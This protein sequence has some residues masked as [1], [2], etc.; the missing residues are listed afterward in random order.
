MLEKLFISTQKPRAWFWRRASVIP[1]GLWIILV[2]A[3]LVS[4]RYFSV[5]D[6]GTH[7][8]EIVAAYGNTGLIYGIPQSDPN[9]KK[10]T[11]CQ[12]CDSGIGVFLLDTATGQKQLVH[13]KNS[14][15][16]PWIT[17][18]VWPWSPD[19]GLFIYSHTNLYVC[20]SATG[21]VVAELPIEGLGG[22]A[23]ADPWAFNGV[24]ALTWLDSESFVYVSQQRTLHWFQKTTGGQW[25]ER[26]TGIK[27]G[28]AGL[29]T[30]SSNTIAWQKGNRIWSLNLAS[31][32]TSPVFESKTNHL[33]GFN[34]SKAKGEFLMSCSDNGVDS[35]WRLTNVLSA[36]I[37]GQIDTKSPV[38]NVVW[39]NG[40]QPGC[41]YLSPRDPDHNTLTLHPTLSGGPITLFG[42][43]LVE[44]FTASPDGRKLFIVGAVSNEP[45]AGIWQYDAG[46]GDLRNLV[47]Y[48]A[49]PSAYARR[50]DAFHGFSA[51][52]MDYYLYPP[53]DFNRH[54]NKKYPLVI[55]D[56]LF[57]RTDP[58]YQNRT[59][60]P[61]WA[62]MLANS[63]AFVVI[64]ERDR[65]VEGCDQLGNR[66]MSV[67][68]QLAKNPM[69]DT[70]RVFLFGTSMET[71]Y[72]SKLVENKPGLWAGAIL[73]NPSQL[74]NL[75]NLPSGKP[76][77]KILI[78]AGS[79]EGKERFKS[80]QKNAGQRGIPVEFYVHADSG[81]WLLGTKTFYE[82][83]QAMEQ[84]VFDH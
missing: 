54:K 50:I 58:E 25:L 49:H 9:G 26:P 22:T 15:D 30:L 13:E 79:A 59:H 35:L 36:P 17:L 51:H 40:S 78:S 41:A 37:P 68:E 83:C 33:T 62:P 73:L 75:A 27:A 56:T 46:S 47:S 2:V 32:A 71:V 3:A 84:F 77:P 64:V 45:S 28:L 39:I 29:T 67:Y 70:N 8:Q 12:M 74:P 55:G 53:A 76:V 7:Y 66:I 16:D 23:A 31:R 65:W 1:P 57:K 10:I 60:G 6:V 21:E 5:S 34:Y 14:L 24:K 18:D 4:I 82:R 69:I 61:L 19:G 63:G 20:Q 81:H 80:Y 11:Y 43:G 72:L 38:R 44:A 52:W 42:Q 48:T